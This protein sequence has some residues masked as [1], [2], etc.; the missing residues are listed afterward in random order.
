MRYYHQQRIEIPLQMES[1]I[2]SMAGTLHRGL[3]LTVDYGYTNEEWMEPARRNGSLRGYYKHKLINNILEHPG[4]MDITSHV[5]FDALTKFGNHHELKFVH[6]WRQDV[7]QF[8]IESNNKSY[9]YFEQAS[10]KNILVK[11][12]IEELKELEMYL[13]YLDL[14]EQCVF[15]PFL[16]RGL[17][18]YTGTIYEIFLADQSIKSSILQFSQLW[19]YVGSNHSFSS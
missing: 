19:K 11:Q 4:D 8:L 13:E 17:E 9:S 18:I 3:V 7:E 5:H 2:K 1:M 16:A 12:G 15:N 10:Q 6:K 14:K